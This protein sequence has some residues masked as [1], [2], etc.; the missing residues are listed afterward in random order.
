MVEPSRRERGDKSLVDGDARARD[1]RLETFE[2]PLRRGGASRLDRPVD[3]DA[4][5]R[6]RAR[7]LAWY[8][9]DGADAVHVGIKRAEDVALTCR[10]AHSA[11]LARLQ[12]PRAEPGHLPVEP[13]D[14]ERRPVFG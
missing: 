4:L 11:D 9:S 6:R 12:R 5:A 1:R 3:D 13:F 7:S 10:L 14:I 2:L 8:A